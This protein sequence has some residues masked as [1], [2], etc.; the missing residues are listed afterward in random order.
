MVAEVALAC[1]LLVSS[2]LLVRTV[3]GMMQVPLGVDGGSVVVA[4]VQLT[5]ESSSLA[6]WAKVGSLHRQI[7]ERLR[8]QSGIV[9]A[10]STNRLPIENGWGG[11]LARPDQATGN[12][13]DLPQAQ[14][15]SVSEGYFETMGARLVEG[16]FFSDRDAPGAEAV[17][18]LNQ[19]AA[20]RYF[21]AESAIGRELRS[22]SS[23]MGPLGR[24]LTWRELDGGHR[25]QPG[26]RVIGVVA[27]IQNVAL[28]LTVEPAAYL[29]TRQFPFAAVSLAIDARDTVSAVAALK[30]VLRQISPYSGRGGRNMAGALRDPN[31]RAAFA[32]EH[33][34]RLRRSRRV[35]CGARGLRAL[36]V[37]R[38]AAAPGAGDPP[39]PRRPAPLGGVERDR[40]ERSV[41]RV[42]RALSSRS[43]RLG[44]GLGSCP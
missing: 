5:P 44:S 4:S 6:A 20:R 7:L 29:P 9:S 8:E 19:T 3:S 13:N 41:S 23:Q 26:L 18:I 42:A 22:W 12:P 32:D 28:G 36:L 27:D 10:G 34:Q 11:P 43:R 37:V 17:V 33:A 15:I 31:R 16:R 40:A 1:A 2:V 24:N 38:G 30:G 25:V 14:H 39:D 35:S 21:G